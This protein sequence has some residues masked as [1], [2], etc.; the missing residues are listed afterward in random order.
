MSYV[1]EVYVTIKCHD[2]KSDL[3]YLAKDRTQT[4]NV[5]INIKFYPMKCVW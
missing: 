5:D 2:I 3:C 4:Q 1:T